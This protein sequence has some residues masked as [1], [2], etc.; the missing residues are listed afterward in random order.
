MSAL[1]PE[2]VPSVMDM[3]QLSFFRRLLFYC[4]DSRA[5]KDWT[6]ARGQRFP[7]RDEVLKQVFNNQQSAV[8][9]QS[10]TQPPGGSKSSLGIFNRHFWQFRRFWQ[11][12]F[13]AEC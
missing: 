5:L 13:P 1:A 8:S 2:R 4:R 7:E 3:E 9:I 11:S 6:T 12:G 10:P